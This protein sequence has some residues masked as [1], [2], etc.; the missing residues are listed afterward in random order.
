MTKLISVPEAAWIFLLILT[1]LPTLFAPV[2]CGLVVLLF[3]GPVLMAL[4]R[5]S[6]TTSN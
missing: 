2:S 1:L 3:A 4:R 6:R 5:S